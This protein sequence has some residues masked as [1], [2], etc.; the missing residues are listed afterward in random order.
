[1]KTVILSISG[2]SCDHCVQAVVAALR[3][4]AGV[5]SCE[6]SLGRAV[7]TYH[8]PASQAALF[9]AVR[10]AGAYEITGFSEAALA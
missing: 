10:R 5:L 9:S 3:G 1:M 8:E 2:M 4:I 6:V 7:V